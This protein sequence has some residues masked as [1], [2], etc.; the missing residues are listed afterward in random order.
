MKEPVR[1]PVV[2]TRMKMAFDLYETAEA[3][4]RQN[5]R[6]RHPEADEAEIEH[7]LAAWLRHRPGAE[8]GDAAGR[9]S[10]RFDDLR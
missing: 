2:M 8:H 10:R 5:L 9:P 3:I 4:L 6:R 1:D 7:H